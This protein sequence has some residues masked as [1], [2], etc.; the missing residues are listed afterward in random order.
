MS[1]VQYIRLTNVTGF[2]V[3]DDWND[4]DNIIY[5]YGN[6]G[7]GGD[8][9]GGGGGGGALSYSTNINLTSGDLVPVSFA[10]DVW[11][12][13]PTFIMAKSGANASGT[14]GGQGGQASAGYGDVK[15]SGGGGGTGGGSGGSA[16]RG[17]GGGGASATPI[18]DGYDGGDGDF[19]GGGGGGGGIE[20]AGVD[21]VG[22]TNGDGGVGFDSAAGGTGSGSVATDGV[23]GSGGGGG[24]KPS[25]SSTHWAG[26][27]GGYID[28]ASGYI[29]GGGGGGAVAAGETNTG[30]SGGDSGGGGGSSDGSGGEGGA[31]SILIVYNPRSIVVEIAAQSKTAK[32]GTPVHII[33]VDLAQTG[34][35]G[36]ETP[37][38]FDYTYGI[39]TRPNA[40]VTLASVASADVRTLQFSDLGYL[41][42]LSDPDGPKSAP[43]R[44][45]STFTL[46]R[47]L[48]LSLS[49]VSAGFAWGSVSLAR[50]D[51]DFDVD[52]LF[53]GINYSSSDGV[54]TRISI[55]WKAYDPTRKVFVE[56][57]V[58]ELEL[59]FS[60]IAQPMLN[61][62]EQI[63]IPFR[64]ALYLL[65]VPLQRRVYGG[66]GGYDGNETIVGS[67][68]PKLRGGTAS[69]PVQNILPVLID[70]AN[71]IYQ[72][73]DAAGQIYALY[74]G[75]VSGGITFEADTDDL[76]S[77]STT[78]AKYRTDNSRGLFQLGTDAQAEITI[79]ATGNFARAGHVTKVV[80]IARFLMT[81]DIGID[82]TFLHNASFVDI[83]SDYSYDAGVYFDPAVI[84]NGVDAVG[85][86]LQG[87]G[88]KI[89]VDHRGRL[90][91]FV[92]Q[93]YTGDQYAT[94]SATDIGS[95][96]ADSIPD[97]FSPLAYRFRVR[98]GKNWHVQTSGL[99][100]SITPTR[101]QF[102]SSLGPVATWA[103][104]L[105]KL[106]FQNAKDTAIIETALLNQADAQEVSDRLGALWGTPRRAYAIELPLY[107]L[108][109][110]LGACIKLDLDIGL[111]PT[112][113]YGYQYGS[114]YTPNTRTCV[115]YV[116][117]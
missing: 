67:P 50:V 103:D 37:I 79:D 51:G 41:A 100:A 4:E 44:S 28:L 66:S 110:E 16:A 39:A 77:G 78:A 53:E 112:P 61:D 117:I 88:A 76:Y 45:L 23:D 11:F 52:G 99:L 96:R 35:A 30:G 10:T 82:P 55:G 32:P 85:F 113:A 98:Y 92:V 97:E 46:S 6:G 62:R 83:S 101:Q 20:G 21:A 84:W 59:L 109:S 89:A 19:L 94:Y 102:L 60:G 56:P 47:R 107:G 9:G 40:V 26:N 14:V 12:G 58:D 69:K 81:E 2:R 29:A 115:I 7:D 114:D 42:Y 48:N 73:N 27:G 8:G 91:P 111:K 31:G 64:D 63:T 65:D 93:A 33:E 116:V 49:S 57:D 87:V 1:D 86:M 54:P 68:L 3:P 15:R 22:T 24:S 106:R 80:D 13:S 70:P 105:Q 34:I 17:G 71:R 25:D 38:T 108:Q 36:D 43:A 95:I 104:P 74:E 5:C 72:Y 18:H 75:G 90:R